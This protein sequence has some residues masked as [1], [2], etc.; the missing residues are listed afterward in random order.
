MSYTDFIRDPNRDCAVV[1]HRGAWHGA[2][3]N[4]LAAIQRA[5]DLGADIVELDVRR[6]AD[7]VLFLCHDERLDRVA[8]LD[9]EAQSLTM[10]ELGRLALRED[11]GGPHRAPT[12]ER[13][14]TLDAALDL[15]R[16]RIFADLDLKDR[17]LF[18]QVAEAARRMG[19][20]DHV[21]LKTEIRS[22]ADLDWVAA[23]GI[24]PVAFMAMTTLT[25]ETLDQRLALLCRAA[26][27]MAEI[28]FDAL[29]TLEAA[30]ARLEAAGIALWKNTLDPANSGEWTDGAALVDPEAIWGR[31]IRAGISCIQTDEP[32][33]L[34]AWLE[35]RKA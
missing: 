10:A 35:G 20:A 34:R 27:F 4:S 3:E 1:A 12:A 28:R 24:A 15:I 7:G 8:G 9:R 5:V 29:G 21:D 17:A 33:A 14:P 2:P 26:P 22:P 18:A 11:D 19:V 23:Q 25:A 6:S 16:G 13:I 31:L 32:E 30:R